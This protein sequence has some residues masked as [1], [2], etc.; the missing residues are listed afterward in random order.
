VNGM[1]QKLMVMEFIIGLMGIDMKDNGK[2]A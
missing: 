2:Y 1:L